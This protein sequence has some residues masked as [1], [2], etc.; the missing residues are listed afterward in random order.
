MLINAGISLYYASLIW[1]I[2]CSWNDLLTL[3]LELKGVSS[4][5]CTCDE[6][7]Y[8]IT[9]QGIWSK[10]THPKDYPQSEWLI[11]WSDIAG[12]SH[13]KDLKIW[14]I[15]GF[16]SP[17]L[18]MVAEYGDTKKVENELKRKAKYVRTILK[19]K[20]LFPPNVQGE[21]KG[22]IRVDK[23]RH[24]LS[25]VSMLGPSPDWITGLDSVNLCLEN[26]SWV[27]NMNIDLWPIDAGTDNG[28]TYMSPNKPSIPAQK[29]KYITKIDPNHSDSPW[30]DLHAY[31]K[32]SESFNESNPMLFALQPG[33]LVKPIARITLQRLKIYEL[34]CNSSLYQNFV[35][36]YFKNDSENFADGGNADNTEINLNNDEFMRKKLLMMNPG[37]IDQNDPCAATIW[38]GWSPCSVTCGK[39][40]TMK[41]RY[42]VNSDKAEMCKSVNLIEKGICVADIQDCESIHPKCSLT[43][44]GTWTPCS[45]TCGKGMRFRTRSYENEAGALMMGCTFDLME[46]EIC[47]EIPECQNQADKRCQT[48]LWSSWS[49]CTVECG[50]GIRYRSRYYVTPKKAKKQCLEDLIEKESCH[51][52]FGIT[53]EIIENSLNDPHKIYSSSSQSLN[54]PDCRLTLW[55]EWSPCTSSCGTGTRV[56]TRYFVPDLTIKNAPIVNFDLASNDQLSCLS[57]NP[58]L[59]D[60]KLFETEIC[61]GFQPQCIMNV[62]SSESTCMLSPIKGPC[63]GQ[64]HRWYFNV[65]L[66]QCRRFWYGGCQGNLNNFH[67]YLDCKQMCE[68][69]IPKDYDGSKQT[70]RKKVDCMVSDWSEWSSCSKKC[71]KGTKNRRRMIK[72]NPEN[73]GE[74]CPDET[75]QFEYCNEKEC[76]MTCIRV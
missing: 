21:T 38:S 56:R 49:D 59:R 43:H 2:I 41:R 7:L 13:T 53:C 68:M 57:S 71:G 20:G 32:F 25:L 5:C 4:S 29:I 8:Q 67:N 46:K 36:N 18:K 72:R 14:E 10:N 66:K 3:S 64:F 75:Y 6:A 61:Q 30:F 24:F 51:G 15:G 70:N 60:S 48:T 63:R 33:Y 12:A 11:H 76:E 40:I 50:T 58:K 45:A 34:D 62:S 31:Q 28:I 73:G 74:L 65:K 39:G 22:T 69:V 27:P 47:M 23:Y 37:S 52:R 9:F 54:E 26:C 1:M 19:M 35:E 55:S 17:A 42:L 16:A 44:W